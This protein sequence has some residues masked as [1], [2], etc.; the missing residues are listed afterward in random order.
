MGL[1]LYRWMENVEN[2]YPNKWVISR[3]TLIKMETFKRTYRC[4]SFINHLYWLV[5]STPSEK[6]EFVSWDDDIPDMMGKS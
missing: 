2:G 6:Y 1:P 5:V 3:G 4:Y